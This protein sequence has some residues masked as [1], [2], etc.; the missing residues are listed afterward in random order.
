[1]MG[2]HCN[3]LFISVLQL[4]TRLNQIAV[5]ERLGTKPQDFWV[6]LL[7]KY[8]IGTKSVTVSTEVECYVVFTLIQWVIAI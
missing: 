1:M 3:L 6:E 4:E 7:N 5:F 8:L 2:L